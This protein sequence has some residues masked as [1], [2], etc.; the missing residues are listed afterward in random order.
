[1]SSNS[2]TGEQSL[3]AERGA[4]QHGLD[5]TVSVPQTRA[6]T[7]E[8]RTQARVAD[9]RTQGVGP[10]PSGGSTQGGSSGN[11]DYKVKSRASCERRL[12]QKRSV[13]DPEAE[14]RRMIEVTVS[15]SSDVSSPT[16]S[17]ALSDTASSVSL[18][19]PRYE[20]RSHDGA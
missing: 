15:P 7:R 3:G 18:S 16:S 10:G 19:A 13:S 20:P 6:Q 8:A 11:V 1:M 14:K 9:G 17:L 12:Q 5:L 2:K 4:E